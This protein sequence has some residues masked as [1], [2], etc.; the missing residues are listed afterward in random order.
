M[1]D[2]RIDE[3]AAEALAEFFLEIVA[4]PEFNAAVLEDAAE[5]VRQTREAAAS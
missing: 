4:A 1:V 5:R 3:A 2:G